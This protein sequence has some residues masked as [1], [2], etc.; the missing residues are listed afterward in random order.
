[1]CRGK[2]TRRRASRGEADERRAHGEDDG[3]MKYPLINT[4]NCADPSR[5]AAEQ[6][7]QPATG[8]RAVYSALHPDSNHFLR[9]TLSHIQT[10]AHLIHTLM[11]H[12]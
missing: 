11:K 3:G 12:A 9:T 1:M 6:Q 7:Q 8:A 10:H 5:T 4:P 2:E